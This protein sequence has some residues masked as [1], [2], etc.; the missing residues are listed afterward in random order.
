MRNHVHENLITLQLAVWY[1]QCTN[2]LHLFYENMGI[3]K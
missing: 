3:Y 1:N 2:M